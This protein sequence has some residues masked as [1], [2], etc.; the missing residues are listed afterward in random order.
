MSTLEWYLVPRPPLFF[1]I[2]FAFSI[3]HGSGRA[4]K[5]EEDLGT[6]IM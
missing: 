1:V 2:Q 5:N 6:L 4:A 3:I